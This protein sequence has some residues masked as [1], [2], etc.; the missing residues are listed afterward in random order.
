MSCRPKTNPEVMI[1]KNQKQTQ[2]TQ[3]AR[4]TLAKESVY[5]MIKGNKTSDRVTFVS[6][7]PYKA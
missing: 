6:L 3:S 7:S 1:Q 5:S 4:V 2:G